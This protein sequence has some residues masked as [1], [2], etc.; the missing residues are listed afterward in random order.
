MAGNEV[1][2]VV[3]I[4]TQAANATDEWYVPIPWKGTHRLKAIKFAPATA[5]AIN[6]TDY[7]TSTFTAN[8]GAAGSDSSTIASHTTNTGGTALVLKTTIN[9]TLTQ[10]QDFTEGQQIKIAKTLA[11]A[12]QI[13]D[14]SYVFLWEKVN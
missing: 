5:V 6:G 11:G 4:P 9:L 14:G 10:V 2:L 7:L 3:Q 1:A 12:G 13:L 8:D